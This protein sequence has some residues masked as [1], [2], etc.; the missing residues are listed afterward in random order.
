MKSGL[1][2][3]GDTIMI[4]DSDYGGIGT[5]LPILMSRTL[6]ENKDDLTM[7]DELRGEL[8]PYK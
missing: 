2:C 4:D 1:L 5:L 3:D 7:K 8:F 6:C